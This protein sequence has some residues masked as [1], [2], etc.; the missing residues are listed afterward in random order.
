LIVLSSKNYVITYEGKQTKLRYPTDKDI[1]VKE[2]GGA[3]KFQEL[4][5][6]ERIR[7]M[8][9]SGTYVDVGANVGNHT[10][11]FANF[12]RADRVIAIEAHPHIFECLQF[13]VNQNSHKTTIQKMNL[14]AWDRPETLWM[15][16]P[17]PGNS[18]RS[19]IVGL[20]KFGKT[21]RLRTVGVPLDEAINYVDDVSLI[22]I[23]VEDAEMQVLRGARGIIGVQKPV[24]V[25]EAHDSRFLKKHADFLTPLGYKLDPETFDPRG[26]TRLWTQTSRA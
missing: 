7:A 15:D 11:Y 9:L 14:A 21:A 12:C 19:Q 26:E 17:V 3:G 16:L 22:K 4:R 8:G 13:N 10:L 2:G 23:D 6:L 24:V 25:T 20:G 1:A 5:L 18:G